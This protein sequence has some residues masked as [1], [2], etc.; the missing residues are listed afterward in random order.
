LNKVTVIIADDQPMMRAGFRSVLEANGI[1]VIAEA[2]T[3][4]E[5]VAAAETHHPDV[6]LMD[7]R[8]PEMDGIEATRRLPRH[9]ILIL[10][11][12]SWRR[13]ARAPAD[14]CSKTHQPKRWCPP[15]GRSPPAMQCSRLP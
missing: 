4:T 14:F 13:Y 5:A 12:T 1:A 8:M 10:T 15:F 9:R 11:S 6:V 7:I 3:G 2:S